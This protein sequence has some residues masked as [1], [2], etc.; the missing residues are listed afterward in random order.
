MVEVKANKTQTFLIEKLQNFAT[1]HSATVKYP[2]F[3]DIMSKTLASHDI[4]SSTAR[5]PSPGNAC[6]NGIDH[7]PPEDSDT[8]VIRR[9]PISR[10]LADMRAHIESLLRD[11]TRR[12]FKNIVNT[13]TRL[14]NRKPKLVEP[15]RQKLRALV[16]NNKHILALYNEFAAAQVATE[17]R[18][19]YR[20]PIFA[21]LGLHE[22]NVEMQDKDGTGKANERQRHH[23]ESKGVTALQNS[24]LCAVLTKHTDRSLAPKVPETSRVVERAEQM[25]CKSNETEQD[26]GNESDV[27]E[28]ANEGQ[29][30][31]D[32][33]DLITVDVDNHRQTVAAT[34]R[35]RVHWSTDTI[36]LD[37]QTNDQANSFQRFE[38]VFI[39][40]ANEKPL[41]T[42]HYAPSTLWS[43][44][45]T[46]NHIDV[47]PVNNP[48][49]FP[50]ERIQVV[51]ASYYPSARI[52]NMWSHRALEGE[53]TTV[54]ADVQ[55]GPVNHLLIN[56]ARIISALG[57]REGT[58]DTIILQQDDFRID[59][60][61]IIRL[62][63]GQR[64]RNLRALLVGELQT[65][66]H[67]YLHWLDYRGLAD[68]KGL[69]YA[70][71]V[72]RIAVQLGRRAPDV[73]KEIDGF[74]KLEQGGGGKKYRE[75]RL[76]YL[77]EDPVYADDDTHKAKAK[78][79]MKSMWG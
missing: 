49:A 34:Q 66:R 73:W 76:R 51:Q 28:D 47:T 3:F 14:G 59:E 9:P 23:G 72:R 21:G 41:T 19:T 57:L 36:V 54:T 58:N 48:S 25:G 68:P 11:A 42:I 64:V 17:K 70:Q 53:I 26:M 65:A 22:Q 40:P 62:L 24:E 74:W 5:S 44:L 69:P 39:T 30:L 16:M 2:Q 79:E 63:P 29:E 46:D 20:L 4:R 78:T 31:A 38:P 15:R 71:E 75:H 45:P 6:S 35:L 52:T 10:T 60:T 8:I 77:G 32:I 33:S 7:A 18:M 27:Q 67:A 37:E 43:G 13:I 56:D 55:D 50:M 61:F 12:E 1:L